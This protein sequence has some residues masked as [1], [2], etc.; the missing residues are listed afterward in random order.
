MLLQ[1]QCFHPDGVD[2]DR[3]ASTVFLPLLVMSEESTF[4]LATREDFIE[5]LRELEEKGREIGTA[6]LQTQI[7]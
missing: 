2:Y 4:T 6:A 3:W 7:T 1:D 5:H